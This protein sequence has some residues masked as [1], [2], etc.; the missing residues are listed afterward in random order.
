[1]VN[2]AGPGRYARTRLRI[3]D[4]AGFFERIGNLWNGFFSLWISG[5]EASN[6]ERKEYGYVIHGQKK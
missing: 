3:E 5:K 6:P 2:M 1:M 4:M